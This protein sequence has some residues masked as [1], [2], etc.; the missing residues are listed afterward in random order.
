MT[1]TQTKS[2]QIADY[3]HPLKNLR[4]EQF[5]QLYVT[6]PFHIGIIYHEAGYKSSSAE[7][8][9]VNAYKVLRKDT[10]RGRVAWLVA[11]RNERLSLDGDNV[12]R[13]LYMMRDRCA[14]G[15]IVLDRQGKPITVLVETGDGETEMRVQWRCDVGGFNRASELLA[16]FHGL[17]VERSE[18]VIHNASDEKLEHLADEF[19]KNLAYS[20]SIKPKIAL[21]KEQ[22]EDKAIIPIDSSNA[23]DDKK[24]SDYIVYDEQGKA[25]A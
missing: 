8:D 16:K 14:E 11:E 18:S 17:L 20:N 7:T 15:H 24:R 6:S 22:M 1:N 4:H 21:T 19:I 9:R 12:I 5:C 13:G 2:D 3:S 23:I 25:V 10:V